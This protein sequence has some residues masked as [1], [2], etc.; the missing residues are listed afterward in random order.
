MY[1]KHQPCHFPWELQMEKSSTT[2]EICGCPWKVLATIQST[3]C[4]VGSRRGG[5]MKQ[6]MCFLPRERGGQRVPLPCHLVPCQRAL[7]VPRSSRSTQCPAVRGAQEKSL[8]RRLGDGFVFPVSPLPSTGDRDTGKASPA[9][10][11]ALSLRYT[12]SLSY[13]PS[14]EMKQRS[15]NPTPAVTPVSVCQLRPCCHH[16]LHPPSLA[17][18]QLQPEADWKED[19]I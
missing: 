9:P 17:T 11:H 8:T 15:I 7:H 2:S 14:K 12:D 13:N 19:M 16:S 5:K 4:T 10:G 3:L 6:G 1:P 18:L